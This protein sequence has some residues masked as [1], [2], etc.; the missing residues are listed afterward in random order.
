MKIQAF[1][2]KQVYF[3]ITIFWSQFG[4]SLYEYYKTPHGTRFSAPPQRNVQFE[5]YIQIAYI[6]RRVVKIIA[7][8]TSYHI[9]TL[10]AV[11][12]KLK[13]R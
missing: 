12:V 4:K 1:N 3:K 10:K 13:T 7:F 6:P 9:K 5:I 2:I 8:K 11:I